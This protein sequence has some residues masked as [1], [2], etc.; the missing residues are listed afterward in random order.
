MDSVL[1]TPS[2][3]T[4]SRRERSSIVSSYSSQM[5][6]SHNFRKFS[7]LQC[8][9]EDVSLFKIANFMST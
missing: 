6:V 5:L 8:D 4:V 1:F 9:H 3:D 2:D 7:P